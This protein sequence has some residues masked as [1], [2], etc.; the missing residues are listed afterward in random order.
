MNDMSRD[1]NQL[2]EYTVN[3]NSH[4]IRIFYCDNIKALY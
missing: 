4:F 3:K 1:I 2:M